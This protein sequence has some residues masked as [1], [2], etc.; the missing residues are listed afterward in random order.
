MGAR[1]QA[2]KHTH[3]LQELAPTAQQGYPH[4]YVPPRA[5][6]HALLFTSYSLLFVSNA[7]LFMF[8]AMSFV[9]VVGWVG[10]PPVRHTP[11]A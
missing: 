3:S 4:M 9:F 6:A 10:S 11:G 5:R 7:L 2:S 8:S 1:A